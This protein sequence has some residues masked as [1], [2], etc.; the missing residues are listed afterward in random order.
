MAWMPKLLAPWLSSYYQIYTYDTD[1]YMDKEYLS[2]ALPSTW[3][4]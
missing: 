3:K 2:A 1:K 4:Y